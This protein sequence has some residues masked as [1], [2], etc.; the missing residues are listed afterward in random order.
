MQ[1]KV[2]KDKVL[3]LDKET[4]KIHEGE[5]KINK[6]MFEM[7]DEYTSDLS[8]NAVFTKDNGKSWQ[9]SVLNNECDIPAEILDEAGNITLGV[10]AYKINNDK[11]ELR[12]SPFP[13]N[14]KIISGSYNP[15]AEES[16]EI[17]PSQYEQY[18]MA[19]QTGL[20]Q[21]QEA[22]E[23]VNQATEDAT[24]LVDKINQM[25]KN[26]EF[27]GPQGPQGVPGEPGKEVPIGGT[28][29]QVLTKNSDEDLDTVWKDAESTGGLEGFHV[30]KPTAEE[31]FDLAT[32]SEPGIYYCIGA[33]TTNTDYFEN[34]LNTN[35]GYGNF[36][37]LL[38]QGSQ[39]NA[40]SNYILRV[41]LFS[42]NYNQF[43]IAVGYN[44]T[45]T[46]TTQLVQS[47]VL[48]QS[49]SLSLE[50]SIFIAS[51]KA[52]NKLAKAI[53][54]DT[55]GVDVVSLTSLLTDDKSSLVAAINELKLKV[56]ELE[57][58]ESR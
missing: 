12:Y 16:Q 2:T 48:P 31:H 54:F 46:K 47:L 49:D 23:E 55:N 15:T 45:Q 6:L 11:L 56:D 25:L 1:V 43:K 34:K 13:T 51:T 29:G 27:I 10:Y 35:L 14:F 41:E 18:M 3:I 4:I 52:V 40:N 37:E 28:K 57:N 50:S 17:T 9:M 44:N 8:I 58:K 20:N 38:F 21:V 30:L 22:I 33:E 19:L 42:S 53:G 7:S 5:Y 26:G 32:L 36:I 24:N 39:S